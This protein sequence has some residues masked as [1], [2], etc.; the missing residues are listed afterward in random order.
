MVVTFQ[1]GKENIDKN[2]IES[3]RNCFKNHDVLKVK[4]LK[5]CSRDK[6]QINAKA[7]EII[8]QLEDEKITFIYKLIGFTIILQKRKNH[9]K[10]KVK[11]QKSIENI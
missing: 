8:K 11:R 6:E 2:Y 4:V 9:K 1:L 3:L 7:E 5:A 10:K